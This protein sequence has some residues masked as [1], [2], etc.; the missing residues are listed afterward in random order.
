MSPLAKAWIEAPCPECQRLWR[1]SAS[2]RKAPDCP[3]C[4]KEGA[5]FH[6]SKLEAKGTLQG[7]VPCGHDQLYWARDFPKKLGIAVV[8]VAAVLAPF[9]YYLSLLVGA[10]LDALLVV[11]IP[12]RLHCYRCG[13]IHHRFNGPG[14][15]QPFQ[16]EV[17]DVHQYGRKAS[18]V[19]ALGHGAEPPHARR[20]DLEPPESSSV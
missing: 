2:E 17:A 11:V 13:A 6:P 18:V 15:W 1:A 8:V 16:L 7:C 20:Q 19:Q 5:A 10:L 14:L 12:K 4:G 9:T 3:K